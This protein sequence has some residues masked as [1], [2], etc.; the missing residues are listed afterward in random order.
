MKNLTHLLPILQQAKRDLMA[1]YP[2]TEM[3][4]FGSYARD[5]ADQNSDLDIL[6][7]Y[8]SSSHFTFFDLLDAEQELTLR[9]GIP[10]RFSFRSSIAKNPYLEDNIMKDIRFL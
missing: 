10:V 5:E 2:I 9:T 7:D 3:G 8:P 6:I 4:I 1:R